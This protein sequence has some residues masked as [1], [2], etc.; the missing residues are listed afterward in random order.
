MKSKNKKNILE[1]YSKFVCS[2]APAIFVSS[3]KKYK[4]S[5]SIGLSPQNKRPMQSIFSNSAV[6]DLIR[7]DILEIDWFQNMRTVSASSLRGVTNQEISIVGTVLLPVIKE[8]TRISVVFGIVRSLGVPISLGA[9]FIDI[10]SK[11]IFPAE[12]SIVLQSS[13][14]VPIISTAIRT[15]EKQNSSKQTGNIVES[16]LVAE[17]ARNNLHL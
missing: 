4:D 15:V 7:E 2:K 5:I 12:H 13:A 16:N 1:P 10:F 14:A 11:G 6:P 3:R 17:E 8:D 9:T